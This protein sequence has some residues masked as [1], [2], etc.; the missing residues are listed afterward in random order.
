MKKIFTSIKDSHPYLKA[1][2]IVGLF[3]LA[4]LIY[5][6][7]KV[8]PVVD[9]TSIQSG[10]TLVAELL[11]VM[12]GALLVVIVLLIDQL[13]QAESIL[14]SSHPAYH[15]VFKQ[16]QRIIISTRNRF[17]KLVES[18]EV[19]LDDKTSKETSMTFR[20]VISSLTSLVFYFEANSAEME[21]QLKKIGFSS[22]EISGIWVNGSAAILEP[23]VFFRTLK[24]AL[25]IYAIHD[26]CS[27][28]MF[29]FMID[30]VQGLFRDGI[31]RALSRYEISR[32]FLRSW[33]LAFALA[34]T[35]FTLFISIFTIFGVTVNTYESLGVL[36]PLCVS[37]VGFLTSVILSSF[38]IQKMFSV[39]ESSV[40]EQYHII[41]G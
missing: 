28:S 1:I 6:A 39:G 32:G 36:I 14:E 19:A 22:E 11:G 35:T 3:L 4:Y 30:L 7:I 16:H 13:H 10:L 33:S 40:T 37:I 18:G 29:K 41:G 2:F 31:I 8:L 5:F 26:W 20:D 9:A 17:L 38:T 27:K 25:N 23:Y 12:L 34:I 24:N 15:S 21:E